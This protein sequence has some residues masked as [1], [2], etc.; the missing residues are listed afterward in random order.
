MKSQQ[1]EG[2]AF[3]EPLL[4]NK[5]ARFL[6]RSNGS[7]K[8]EPSLC[9]DFIS[10]LKRANIEKYI[11]LHSNLAECRLVSARDILNQRFPHQQIEQRHQQ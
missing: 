8:A 11:P 3:A 9:C 5:G 6:L 2:S 4:R 10:H 7:A 1:R